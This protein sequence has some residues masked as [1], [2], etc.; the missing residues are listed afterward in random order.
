VC[1][2]QTSHGAATQFAFQ[3]NTN[4]AVENGSNVGFE[5]HASFLT[6]STNY[7]Q[8]TTNHWQEK[9]RRRRKEKKEEKKKRKRKKEKKRKKKRKKK[10]KEHF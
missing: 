1:S 9:K 3:S 10:K 6:V 4:Q 2:H 7:S 5:Q 8:A